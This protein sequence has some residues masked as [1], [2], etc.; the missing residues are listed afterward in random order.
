MLPSDRVNAGQAGGAAT[1]PLTAPF[2][3][4]LSSCPCLAAAVQAPSV[5]CRAGG[6][7]TCARAGALGACVCRK[8]FPNSPRSLNSLLLCQ[9]LIFPSWRHSSRAPCS[10]RLQDRRALWDASPPP[11]ACPPFSSAAVLCA[12][13]H[14][15]VAFAGQ[16]RGGWAFPRWCVADGVFIPASP[17]AGPWLAAELK[18]G[19]LSRGSPSLAHCPPAAVNVSL[20]RLL[21]QQLTHHDSPVP[22]PWFRGLELRHHACSLPRLEANEFHAFL[23]APGSFPAPWPSRGV[24]PCVCL[25]PN[26]PFKKIFFLMFVYL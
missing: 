22:V 7:H 8:L 21:S 2:G 23:L 12:G 20:L 3:P 14:P 11:G 1:L 17:R 16:A 9:R 26:A 10:S 25:C 13:R 4:W 6:A 24:S 19:D 18:A 15:V 5:V